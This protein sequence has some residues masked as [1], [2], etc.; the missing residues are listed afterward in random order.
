MID[1]KQIDWWQRG[2]LIE[3]LHNYYNI[4][5]NTLFT[6]SGEERTRGYSMKLFYP[7]VIH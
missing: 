7:N 4:T 3:L 6:I 2:D 5:S 1:H